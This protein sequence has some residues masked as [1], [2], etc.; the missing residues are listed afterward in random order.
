MD[1]RTARGFRA[2]ILH[3]ERSTR[4]KSSSPCRR[5]TFPLM[6]FLFLSCF[7]LSKDVSSDILAFIIFASVG[8]HII[9]IA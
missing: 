4:Q 3:M 7:F 8:L 1:D 2:F 9:S 6:F 5:S